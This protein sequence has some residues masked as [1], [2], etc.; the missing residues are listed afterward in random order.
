MPFIWDDNKY[1]LVDDEDDYDRNR[2]VVARKLFITP[3]EENVKKSVSVRI[4]F[5]TNFALDFRIGF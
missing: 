5:E 3:N 2:C 1:L 4:N